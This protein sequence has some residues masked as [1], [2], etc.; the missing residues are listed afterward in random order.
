M[1]LKKNSIFLFYNNWFFLI[2]VLI[3]F[4]F[5]FKYC[6]N[7]PYQDDFFAVLEFLNNFKYSLNTFQKLQLIFSQHNEHR[8]IYDRIVILLQYYLTGTTNFVYLNII[9]SIPLL[10]LF[11]FF[12]KYSNKNNYNK[13]YIYY[14]SVLLFNLGFW[15]NT[16]FGMASL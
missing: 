5:L 9:G 3:Y 6:I 11:L 14:I 12:S 16:Y 8:I 1:V 15:Q 13:I 4:F 10:I 7:F 2:P